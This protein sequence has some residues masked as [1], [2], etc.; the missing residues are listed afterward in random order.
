MRH[1]ERFAGPLSIQ[2]KKTILND[3]QGRGVF[4][5][6]LIPS[7]TTIDT[8]PALVLGLEENVKHIEHT[9]LYHYT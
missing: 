8:C 5:T 3:C 4:A 7:K 6:Q 2:I 1:S 9:S